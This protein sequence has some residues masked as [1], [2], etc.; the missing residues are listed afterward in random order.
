[1]FINRSMHPSHS[2]SDNTHCVNLLQTKLCLQREIKYAV[3]T[4][5]QEKL[6]QRVTCFR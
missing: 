1:M 5:L 3:L 4:H 6:V 2:S